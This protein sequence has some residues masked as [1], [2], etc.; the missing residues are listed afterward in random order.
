MLELILNVSGRLCS[1]WEA[2]A[3][4]W[5]QVRGHTGMIRQTDRWT[6]WGRALWTLV[7]WLKHTAGRRCDNSSRPPPDGQKT[8]SSNILY[9][10]TAGRP[11]LFTTHCVLYTLNWVQLTWKTTRDF[12]SRYVLMLAPMMWYRRLKPIWMYFPKRLLL[13]FRVVL[14]FP[15]ACWTDG[16]CQQQQSLCELKV[17][18]RTTGW[19]QCN[20]IC[21]HVSRTSNMLTREKGKKLTLICRTR[22]PLPVSVQTYEGNIWLDDFL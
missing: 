15:M 4:T 13:S 2:G 3:G 1:K 6:H 22:N 14:A 12:S 5:G 16:Q 17:T 7:D 19:T 18:V 20:N 9:K 8:N 11:A 21:L 10:E